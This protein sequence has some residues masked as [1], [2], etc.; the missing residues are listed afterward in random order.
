MYLW[1]KRVL[2]VIVALPGLLFIS[3][4]LRWLVDPAG[5]A[6]QLGLTLETGLGLSSQ[7]G[8]LAGFLLVAGLSIFAALVT[9]N[10]TWYYPPV[11][12]LSIAATGRLIAWVVHGAS[13]AI[14]LIVFEVVVALLLLA[15]SRVLP[16]GS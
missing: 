7:I 6:P 3:M 13:F 5:V 15:A 14:G 9:G 4:G 8:D 2:T 1:G 16:K 12:L 11:M 10:R